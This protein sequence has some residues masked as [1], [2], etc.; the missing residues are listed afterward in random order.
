MIHAPL[1]LTVL[2]LAVAVPQDA[3]ADAARLVPLG[4]FLTLRVESAESLHA[5]GARMTAMA[6]EDVPADA[7]ALLAEMDLPGDTS[8]IDVTRPGYVALALQGMATMPTFVVPVRDAAAFT[9]SLA[10]DPS[11]HTAVVGGYVGISQQP[12]YAAL[13]QPNPLV[14]ALRPGM[15]SARLDLKSLIQTF[16]PMI[17][18]GMGQLEMMMDQAALEMEQDAPMDMAALLEVYVEGIWAF[19]DSADQ[20]DLALA[21]DGKSAQLRSWL[22]TLPESP[23]AA[24][25]GEERFDLRPAARWIDP[26]AGFSMVM[27]CDMAK[28]M[29]RFAPV[30]DLVFDA[31]PPDF[32]AELRRFMDAYEPVWPLLGDFTVASGDLGPGGLR[33][34]YQIL[35]PDPAALA[36][37]MTA[38]FSKL[39]ASEAPSKSFRISAPQP[40]EIGGKTVVRAKLDVDFR[41]LTEGMLE[42]E[43]LDEAQFEQMQS[44]MDAIYGPDG[45]QMVWTPLQDRLTMALGGDDAFAAAAL[46]A[47]PR[48][49]ARLPAELRDAIEAASGGSMGLVYRIDYGRLFSD[50]APMFAGMGLPDMEE[51]GAFAALDLRLPITFW[52]GIADTTWSSGVG[53][54]LD[55]LEAVMAALQEL[56]AADGSEDDSED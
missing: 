15:A 14:T 43:E 56:D 19:L 26:E 2:P 37:A 40:A 21:Y 8:Q 22:S 32:A 18:M 7:A 12:G 53:M 24:M 55:Q 13:A 39:A 9:A 10:D 25:G 20:L 49:L 46:A 6:G 16:R 11:L 35:C 34:T 31:Y 48:D 41:K 30:M 51:L 3:A 23:M 44:M 1:L 28:T 17:E 38:E 4:S 50:M 42:G 29:E 47:Q 5:L 52:M 36:T 27:A 33:S 45:L 54:D